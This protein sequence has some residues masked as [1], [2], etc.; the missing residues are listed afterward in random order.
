M[1]SLPPEERV[2]LAIKALHAGSISSQRKAAEHFN[3]PR[4]TL[5]ERLKGRRPAKELHQAQQRVTPEE[6]DAIKR[7]LITMTAWGFSSTIRYLRSLAVGIQEA[8]GDYE[9]LGQHWY[10]HYLARHPDLKAVWSRNLDQSR[11]DA[12]DHSTLQHWFELYQDT[13]AK[14][15]IPPADQYN[16]DEKGFMKGISDNNKVII[17]VVEEEAWAVQLGNRD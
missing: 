13:C 17:P 8:R 14:Y 11:K 7:T 6:E 10:K 3:I 15:G 12:V 5:Q 9:P 4:S 1:P 16:M 2:Q